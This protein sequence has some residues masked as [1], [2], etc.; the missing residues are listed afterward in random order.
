MIVVKIDGGLGNQMFQYAFG[1]AVS[2]SK[3]IPFYYEKHAL[4]Y[5]NREFVLN[6]FKILDNELKL[7]YAKK[8]SKV[9]K[10][11]AA[12]RRR[13]LIH[14]KYHLKWTKEKQQDYYM[15]KSNYIQYN[16]VYYV[17]LFQN[18]NYFNECKND[19][20]TLFTV[21]PEFIC[22][23]CIEIIDKL[24]AENTC[25]LHIRKGDYPT[26][27]L[28]PKEYY[29]KAIDLVRSTCGSN[30]KFFVFCEN[31]DYAEE[32]L[33]NEENMFFINSFGHFSD[34]EEFWMMSQMKHQIISNSTFSWWAAY[35][36]VNV[37]KRVIAPITEKFP[38]SFYEAE[39]T[40]LD[41]RDI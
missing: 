10:L 15:Y 8:N 29:I 32:V 3:G 26:D 4:H 1:Y 28:V 36:N 35:L 34:I 19:I 13:E 41:M 9:L 38:Q 18:S 17:G 16:D 30:V 5:R 37:N 21:K 12:L 6:Q 14:F 33:K 11:I 24:K 31:Q 2:K 39:W 25:A 27:W 23:K 20:K 7:P 40:T 22:S